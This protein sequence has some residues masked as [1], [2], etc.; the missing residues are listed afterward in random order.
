MNTP[1]SVDE[2]AVA[3]PSEPATPSRKPVPDGTVKGMTLRTYLWPMLERGLVAAGMALTACTPPIAPLVRP[4]ASAVALT[5]GVNTSMIYLSRAG[6]SLIAID[7]GWWRS[8][9][10]VRD[11]LRELGASPKEVSDVFLTHSHRDHIGAWRMLRASRFNVADAER[12]LLVG[13]SQH[14]GWIPRFAEHLKPSGLPRARDIDVRTFSGDTAFVFG[15]D[16]LHAFRVTGHTA[17][18]TVYLFRG[19][20]FLGDAVTYTPW[21]GFAPAKRGFS[22]DTQLAT[23]SLA[24]LWNRLPRRAVH[25]VCT[26]HARCRPFSAEFLADVG[27]RPAEAS[28]LYAKLWMEPRQLGQREASNAGAGAP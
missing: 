3:F 16:T 12:P 5:G 25:Y 23:A 1:V 2:S 21:S 4:H 18:S 15:T 10:A 13:D 19:A 24:A 17:G 22:D 6:D 14:R 20:L 27:V 28:E 26:A 9:A 11:A 8:E 7:L